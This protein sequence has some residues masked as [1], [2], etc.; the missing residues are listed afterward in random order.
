[1]FKITDAAA[2]QILE[3]AKQSEAEGLALRVAAKALS[4][5]HIEYGMGFDEPQEGDVRVEHGG[6]TVVIDPPSNDLLDD[7]SMDYV[8]IEPGQH[9]FI[10]LNPL[11]PHYQPPKKSKPA[12]KK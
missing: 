8:E 2:Q 12:E 4:D 11:D 5:G 3:A 10:F 1:M 7:A 9:R 6:V